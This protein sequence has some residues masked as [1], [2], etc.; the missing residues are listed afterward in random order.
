MNNKEKKRFE[1]KLWK[2][3]EHEGVILSK[4]V[5][6]NSGFDKHIH[7]EFAIGVISHGEMNGFIDGTTKSINKKS[8]MTINPDTAHSNNAYNQNMYSQSAVNIHPSF[9]STLIKENFSSKQVYF[10]TGLLEHESLSN[11]FIS[12]MTSFENN[13]LSTID[14]ECRLVE[15]LNKILLANTCVQEQKS[16]SKHDIA[17]MRA[18]EFMQDNLSMDIT[19]DDIAQELDLSKFHFL[20]LFKKHTHFSP[21]VYLMLKRLE[22]AKQLLQ[23]GK[24]IIDAVYT[25]GFADQSHLNKHFKTY[26]G[27]TPKTYQKFFL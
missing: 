5:F 9:L 8:I 13:E 23:E 2:P 11:E 27:L 16:L 10:K 14:Y 19:L 4:T 12:L 22:R 20:R 18:K 24:S 26:M 6:N 7:E 1:S 21:H 17:I 3:I 25:C 15:V